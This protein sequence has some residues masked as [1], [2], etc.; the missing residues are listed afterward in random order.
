MSAGGLRRSRWRAALTAA[1]L[2]V[3]LTLSLAPSASAFGGS[4][5][6]G[7]QQP[8][9][10]TPSKP[11]TGGGTPGGSTPA[12]YG[13]WTFNSYPPAPGVTL[14]NCAASNGAGGTYVATKFRFRYPADLGLSAVQNAIRS[15]SA[16]MEKLGI[17]RLERT[18][19]YDGSFRNETLKCVV[20]STAVAKMIV[21]RS[22]SLASETTMSA[23]GSGDRSIQA[24][25]N[26]KTEA[27]VNITPSEYGR[28][29]VD[30]HSRVVNMTIQVATAPNGLT[31]VWEAPRI[32]GTSGEYTTNPFLA[33]GYLT[34]HGW[35][36]GVPDKS[37]QWNA[38]DCG[39]SSG[40]PGDLQCLVGG[41][42]LIGFHGE[43]WRGRDAQLLRDGSDITMA[44]DAPSIAGSGL[45]NIVSTRS[46]MVVADAPWS[47]QQPIASNF[48]GLQRDSARQN[49]LT[50][51]DGTA[52]GT[53]LTH[54]WTAQWFQATV[55]PT[56]LTP[57]YGFTADFVKNSVRITGINENGFISEPTQVI[58]R[59]D[60]ACSG[61]PVSV[62]MLRVVNG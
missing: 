29:R 4:S 55:S 30:A 38:N 22:V 40:T 61:Q 12:K 23:Y 37:Y 18:C 21:P 34:C 32:V 45:Q 56:T 51:A 5:E 10:T 15:G 50:S 17:E 48:F 3:M 43:T 7:A 14:D 59:A 25:R 19:L 62:S 9:V 49:A 26:S 42:P 6:D 27:R 33:D 1:T 47:S 31:G 57:Q 46:R 54:K 8:P 39:G 35:S 60:A 11:V 16:S 36:L 58:V 13:Y 20:S 52:W 28:Y 53:G 2:S 24:C 44:W 41:D